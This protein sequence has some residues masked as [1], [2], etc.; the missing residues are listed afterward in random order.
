MVAPS[1]SFHIP[2][3]YSKPATLGSDLTIAD[4]RWILRRGWFLPALGACVGAAL[5]IAYLMAVPEVYNSSARI[6]LERTVNRYLQTSNIVDEP[7]LDD[8]DIGGQ[9][10]VLSSD[11]II[12]PV[13]QSLKLADD[14]EFVGQPGNGEKRGLRK[15]VSDLKNYSLSLSS[16]LF[17]IPA[18]NLSLGGWKSTAAKID[19]NVVRE[20]TAVET[21]L[22][23]LTVFREDAPNVIN[24]TVA[25]RDPIKAATIANAIADRYIASIEARKQKSSKMISQLLEDRLIEFKRQSGEANR[26]LQEF[27][28]TH[29]V[30]GITSG[31]MSA[32]GGDGAAAPTFANNELILRLRTQYVDLAAKA[33]ELEKQLGPTHLAVVKLHNQ[34][35]QL[36]EAMKNEDQRNGLG[37]ADQAKLRDLESSAATLHSL[38]DSA[39]R[40]FNEINQ[41]KPE[42]E[43]AHIIARAAPPLSKSY[44]KSIALLGGGF[45]FGLLSGAAL[46]VGRE[47]LASVFRTPSQ[48]RQA[49][50]MYCAVL[51][52]IEANPKARGGIRDYVL[53][54]PYTRFTE[55]IRN[56]RAMLRADQRKTNN[57]VVG[58]ISAASN[59]GKTTVVSNLAALLGAGP[60]TRV[61]VI[62]C[63]LHRRTVTAE[64]APTAQEGLLEVLKDT[65][66]LQ[67]LIIKRER[68]GFDVLPCALSE[69]NPHA[70]ELLG[71]QQMEKLLDTVRASYDFI[72]LEIPPIMSVVDIKMIERFVDSF[73]FVIEWGK[74][75][76]GLVEEALDE[77]RG[78][79]NR[80]L[81]ALLNK[82]DPA[83]LRT[84]EAYRGA[85]VGDYYVG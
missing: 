75:K 83:A 65:S 51:P 32:P 78:I 62:D 55:T 49:T 54:A 42:T 8:A 22:K 27:I 50:G 1:D 28:T 76:R 34:M 13:V 48:V 64:L 69:R 19:P 68:S 15:F 37:D 72:I 77:V 66:R 85:R 21:L 80:V 43:D 40:K 61:L 16:S 38:Y 79:R 41:V 81:C 39:L 26:A 25:S 12:V 56:V 3:E 63:D 7:T 20:R 18:I 14:P 59:E 57:K 67:E 30:V 6:I 84:I 60:G 82:A 5:A 58:I 74:T 10:Y 70:A 36:K 47:W 46:A 17:G 23:Q 73:I 52:T 33:S 29:N 2:D 4:V 53:D 45:M 71:S 44:K 11:S 24:M 31:R 9:I 35:E